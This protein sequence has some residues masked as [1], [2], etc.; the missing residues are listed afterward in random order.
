MTS[1]QVRGLLL[2]VK[3][4][5]TSDPIRGDAFLV[6]YAYA[7]LAYS[8]DGASLIDT[9]C[10]SKSIASGK[11]IPVVHLEPFSEKLLSETTHERRH[12]FSLDLNGA[13]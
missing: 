9:A 13:K 5:R 2:W 12:I 8:H 4:S 6:K 1:P 10:Q 7:S 11:E 3:E